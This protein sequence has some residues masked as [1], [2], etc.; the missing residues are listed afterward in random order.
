MEM[1]LRV[2][3]DET[4]D[5]LIMPTDNFDA[6]ISDSLTSKEHYSEF[7]NKDLSEAIVKP[8]MLVKASDIASLQS[9]PSNLSTM[10][11]F[12]QVNK[13][14]FSRKVHH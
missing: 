14:L 2:F 7:S 13:P 8:V 10:P 6:E 4:Y 11:S 1:R 12:D 3:P 5:T 9:K